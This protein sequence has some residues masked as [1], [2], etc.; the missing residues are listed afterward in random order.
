[1][2]PPGFI[3]KEC[4]LKPASD[5]EHSMQTE[6]LT[7][8]DLVS[9]L[10]A[11]EVDVADFF[12]SLTPDELV[13]RVENAWTA[14]EQLAHL[15]AAVSAVAR[16]FAVPRIILRLRFGRARSSGRSYT[17]LRDDYR[18]R[19]AAGGRASGPFVPNRHD[20]PTSQGEARRRDLLARWHRVNN[21]LQKALESWNEQAL[22]T[23][24]LPHPLLG[25]ITAREMI[26][27]T[28][29]HAKHHVTAT[30]KRL[31]RF[32]GSSAG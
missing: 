13:L 17:A 32:T 16:G 27:F 6:H 25:K 5:P 23:I 9:A 28:L 18:A 22:N 24:R 4:R 2:R 20:L 29:Y 11:A 7:R 8:E 26:Y 15:N 19:L 12:A 3:D 1:M 31:P 10:S 30:K 14:A 21:R